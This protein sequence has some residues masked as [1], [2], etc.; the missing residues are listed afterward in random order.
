MSFSGQ[1]LQGNVIFLSEPISIEASG[2]TLS[3]LL[4]LMGA[5]AEVRL[6]RFLL[7]PSDFP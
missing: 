7:H 5:A 4:R 2:S 3:D 6:T 1:P